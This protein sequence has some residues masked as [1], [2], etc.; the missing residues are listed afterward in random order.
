M[1]LLEPVTE[2]IVFSPL[3]FLYFEHSKTVPM[4]L[5][6]AWVA[7]DSTPYFPRPRFGELQ[8][9]AFLGG[10]ISIQVP[11]VQPFFYIIANKKALTSP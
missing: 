8:H 11:A 9:G 6:G 2:T 4:V 3:Q 7:C 1:V 10:R 5:F